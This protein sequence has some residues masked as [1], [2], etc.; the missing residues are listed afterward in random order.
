MTSR[1]SAT[2]SSNINEFL[3]VYF[4]ANTFRGRFDPTEFVKEVTRTTSGTNVYTGDDVEVSHQDLSELLD[5]DETAERD[6]LIGFNNAKAILNDLPTGTDVRRYYWTPAVK[7]SG[8][9]K[10][11]PSDVMIK[12]RGPG[13]ST[14]RYLGYSNKS[15]SGTDATPKFNTNLK[16]FIEQKGNVGYMEELFGYVD[17]AWKQT[18]NDIIGL[19][20][21]PNSVLALN[22]FTIESEPRSEGGSRKSFS[23]LAQEFAKDGLKFYD[24]DF[25]HP[26]RN[27]VIESV[28]KWLTT[29]ENLL[30]FLQTVG[31]YTFGEDTET[32]CPYKLLVGK[33]SGSTI[34]EISSDQNMKTLLLEGKVDELKNIKFVYSGTSQS[35]NI[36]FDYLDYSVNIPVTM[37][38]RSAGGW[39]GKALF[40]TTPGIKM[41]IGL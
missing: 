17:N 21:A 38:T 15:T 5:K 16:A 13:D 14:D 32:P 22:S 19:D 6:I 3:S 30:Y 41:N 20:T 11:N 34:K 10:S 2:A 25:Y 12:Y 4:L 18:H 28:G 7:P 35:F 29:A 23:L 24:K 1:K 36:N 40:I 39:A 9:H 33:T 8:I 37:R 27:R 31:L 26:F